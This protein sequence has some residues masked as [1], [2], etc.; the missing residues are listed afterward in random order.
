MKEFLPNVFG[1]L[2]NIS[3]GIH[4]YGGDLCQVIIF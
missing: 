3:K 1:D 2:T 4:Q